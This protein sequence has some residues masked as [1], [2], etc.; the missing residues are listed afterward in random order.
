MS[1]HYDHYQRLQFDYPQ[2]RVLR[3]TMNR[4]DKLNAADQRMHRELTDVWRDIDADEEISS[5]ILTG[6]GKAFSAGGDFDM[7]E[8]IIDD[9]ETRARVW[10]EARDVLPV[11]GLRSILQNF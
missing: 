4:E 3:V 2:P 9:F 6:A 8:R 5:V 10:K 1:N 11:I 7:I